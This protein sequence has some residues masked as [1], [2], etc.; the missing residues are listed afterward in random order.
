M[1]EEIFGSVK[2]LYPSIREC[3]VQE[4]G[5]GGLVIRGRGEGIDDF[6]RGN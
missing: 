1:G 2:V 5:M 4:A 6:G 3:Q